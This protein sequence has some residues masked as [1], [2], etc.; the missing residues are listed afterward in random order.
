MNLPGFSAE[1]SLSRTINEYYFQPSA[2][3]QSAG[4]GVVASKDEM[5]TFNCGPC[6]DVTVPG[7]IARTCM[8]YCCDAVSGLNCQFKICTCPPKRKGFGA[9]F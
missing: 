8:K 6:L 7:G 2:A 5:E 4:G 9:I 3:G 1:A